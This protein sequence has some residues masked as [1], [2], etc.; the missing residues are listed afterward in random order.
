MARRR[1]I[2]SEATKYKL[3]AL[4]GAAHK[5]EGNYYGKLTSEECGNMVKYALQLTEQQLAGQ[6]PGLAPWAVTPPPPS[7]PFRHQ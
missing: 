7:A 3:A 2:L 1:S 4:Q 5:I 6:T